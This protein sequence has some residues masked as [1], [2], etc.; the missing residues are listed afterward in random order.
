MIA[1]THGIV[2]RTYPYSET[3]RI[4]VWLS[5]DAG[6]I[7]TMIKGAMRPKNPALGQF[8]L[9]YTCELLY[10]AKES[11]ELHIL[12]ECCPLTL[13]ERF[14]TDW[15]ACAAASYVAG[16]IQRICP[17][18]AV[19]PGLYSFFEG[20]LDTLHAEGGQPALL[21]W[22]ELKVLHRLGHAPRLD[23]CLA[24]KRPRETLRAPVDFVVDRG[25]YLCREC[26]ASGPRHEARPVGLD[27]LATLEAWQR[28][29]SARVAAVTRY[30]NDQD[31]AIRALLGEFLAHHL[32]LS[33]KSRSIAFNLLD[34]CLF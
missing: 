4:V 18:H 1:K 20:L 13:R 28:F 14:R 15:R 7:T 10:Y 21:Y 27:I 32:D 8:D 12:R 17:P 16:L 24:C 33:P 22:A 6:R 11:R 30:T 19:Q 25:G 34:E 3:S 29:P 2:L 31:R 23:R 5:R 9:Y 26:A